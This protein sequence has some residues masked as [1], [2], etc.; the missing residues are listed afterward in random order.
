M[1]RDMQIAFTLI[2]LLVVVAII[3]V[4]AALLLPALGSAREK[5][6]RGV[7]A[8]NLRQVGM[9]TI[10]YA[11]DNNEALPRQGKNNF[12]LNGQVSPAFD[13]VPNYWP[14]TGENDFW[15]VYR[16]YLSGKLNITTNFAGSFAVGLQWK[17]MSSV[18]KC[19]SFRGSYSANGQNMN[20]MYCTGSA[21]NYR[22]TIVNLTVAFQSAAC[23]GG[24]PGGHLGDA[25]A[26][27]ADR[28]QMSPATGT[29][30]LANTCHW[31]SMAGDAAGGNVVHIDG[32][33]RWDPKGKTGGIS[34]VPNTYVSNGGHFNQIFYPSTSLIP[35]LDGNGNWVACPNLY[36][37]PCGS[38]CSSGLFQFP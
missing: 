34:A 31:D 5:A 20:Y 32:S 16:D 37:G 17:Q 7:C 29:A 33:V 22:M 25:A 24:G 2:E 8:N 12:M 11:G 19:P 23:G 18:L 28:M 35:Y 30:L 4:L 36:V 21:D 10:S 27:Y 26:L 13:T 14:T 9:A 1:R 15:I 38:A 3:S 6:Y